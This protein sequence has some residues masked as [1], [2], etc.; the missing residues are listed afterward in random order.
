MG[1][2][3]PATL[4]DAAHMRWG[5][6]KCRKI[7]CDALRCKFQH[8]IYFAPDC[9]ITQPFIIGISNGL[10]LCDGDLMSFHVIYEAILSVKYF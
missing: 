9:G 10:Q 5:V 2:I 6:T 4:C 1:G 3:G 8:V 7:A